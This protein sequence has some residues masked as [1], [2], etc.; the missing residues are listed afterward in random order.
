MENKQI[1]LN[2]ENDTKQKKVFT[3]FDCQNSN[4]AAIQRLGNVSYGETVEYLKAHTIIVKAVHIS[5]IKS[6]NVKISADDLS[7][8]LKSKSLAGEAYESKIKVEKKKNILYSNSCFNIDVLT[9]LQLELPK[10][11]IIELRFFF[12]YK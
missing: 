5:I 9:S 3:L 7:F 11:T 4:P 1:T 2:I 6:T 12:E 10:N 8:I